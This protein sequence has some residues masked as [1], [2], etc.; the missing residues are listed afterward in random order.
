MSKDDEN[1]F[2]DLSGLNIPA[3]DEE[4]EILPGD[5]PAEEDFFGREQNAEKL[6]L[7]CHIMDMADGIKRAAPY[8]IS[9]K[10]TNPEDNTNRG[11]IM[12]LELHSPAVFLSLELRKRLCEMMLAADRLVIT[13]VP[14]KSCT[15]FTCVVTDL[16]RE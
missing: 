9:V 13:A 16:W 7:C 1:I 4:E 12:Y 2:P 3:E 6:A 5:E 15:R 14:E 11:W 8:H 10:S